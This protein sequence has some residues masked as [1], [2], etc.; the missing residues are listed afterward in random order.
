MGARQRISGIGR[1]TQLV[2]FWERFL[3]A[4]RAF[5]KAGGRTL[6]HVMHPTFHAQG[7][8]ILASIDR[9][10]GR[11]LPT[12]KVFFIQGARGAHVVFFNGKKYP[13]IDRKFPEA[14]R[15]K[16]GNRNAE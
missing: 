14:L 7:L 15:S 2:V 4:K 6:E 9:L 16:L 1:F 11:M 5:N 10:L 13:V 12:H 8:K 3:E